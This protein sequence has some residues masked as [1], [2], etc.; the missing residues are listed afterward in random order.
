MGPLIGAVSAEFK[1]QGTFGLLTA[2][3]GIVPLPP[4]GDE[5]FDCPKGGR[6]SLVDAGP[7][8]E[9]QLGTVGY[10]TTCKGTPPATK[11]PVRSSVDA[12]QA[13]AIQRDATPMAEG[14]LIMLIC[15]ACGTRVVPKQ[16]GTCPACQARICSREAISEVGRPAGISLRAMCSICGELAGVLTVLRAGEVIEPPRFLLPARGPAWCLEGF[17]G[18]DWSKLDESRVAGLEDAIRRSDFGALCA[19]DFLLVP[20][21]CQ[22][23]HASYCYK[24]WSAYPRFDP[25]FPGWYEDTVGWCPRGHRRLLDD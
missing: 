3:Q 25:D 14:P 18:S 9:R 21:Y 13:A 19:I 23:C 8:R 6:L 11:G 12:D 4:Q 22:S 10:H 17:M 20:F 24:H 1:R 15:S 2:I 16:N 5:R 7:P